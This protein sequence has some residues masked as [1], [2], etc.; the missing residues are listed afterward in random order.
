MSKFA[1]NQQV[2]KQ[3]SMVTTTLQQQEFYSGVVPKAEELEKYDHI[4]PG[5][6]ERLFKMA[7]IEQAGRLAMQNKIIDTQK[8]LQVKHFSYQKQGIWVG[9][10]SVVLIVAFCSY[11]AYLGAV[12]Q[13]ATSLA[14]TIGLAGIFVIRQYNKKNDSDND[15]K[16]E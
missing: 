1:K 14:V 3:S 2:T 13:A 10:L 9:F 12:T 8:E 15:K 4:N 7:E 5:F 16:E 11:L 6:S